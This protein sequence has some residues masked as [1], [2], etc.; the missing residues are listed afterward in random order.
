MRFHHPRQPSWRCNA[1]VLLAK[2]TQEMGRAEKMAFVAELELQEPVAALSRYAEPG[3]QHRRGHVE[4][5]TMLSLILRMGDRDMIDAAIMSP[6]FLERQVWHESRDHSGG[7]EEM[8]KTAARVALARA[9]L[10]TLR[11]AQSVLAG[12]NPIERHL[13]ADGV[14]DQNEA[15]R[16]FAEAADAN[17]PADVE[18]CA[19][20]LASSRRAEVGAMFKRGSAKLAR[21]AAEREAKASASVY[22][23]LLSLA[24]GAGSSSLARAAVAGGARFEVSHAALCLENGNPALARWAWTSSHADACDADRAKALMS[25][26]RSLSA[27]GA[28]LRSGKDNGAAAG[29]ESI[30]GR[31]GEFV[32]EAITPARDRHSEM[33]RAQGELLAQAM[34]LSR[35]FEKPGAWVRLARAAHP[36]PSP[37]E[38]RA[39]MVSN[40]RAL[41]AQRLSDAVSAGVGAGW[42]AEALLQLVA[43]DNEHGSWSRSVEDEV[44]PSSWRFKLAVALQPLFHGLEH[45]LMALSG[46]GVPRA[47]LERELAAY[48]CGVL[49]RSAPAG[50][51][52]KGGGRRI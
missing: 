35:H 16:Q 26:A 1:A 12:G 2:S 17:D 34:P 19:R 33:G 36:L 52:P 27:L 49:G 3:E 41:L 15:V 22:A 48:E 25:C 10:A 46:M 50:S 5:M 44:S 20:W 32:M 18:E 14:R 28:T 13:R 6:S 43:P 30:K 11:L 4:S 7:S 8:G 39:L 24:C 45:P 29:F 31:L 37:S 42:R 9:D 38:A 23:E 47:D 51:E 40:K 21:E